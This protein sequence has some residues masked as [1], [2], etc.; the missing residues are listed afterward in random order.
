MLYYQHECLR[1]W[2]ASIP[3]E[4]EIFVE[5]VSQSLPRPRLVIFFLWLEFVRGASRFGRHSYDFA[6]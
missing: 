5:E 6:L 2:S 1:P 3:E 4:I